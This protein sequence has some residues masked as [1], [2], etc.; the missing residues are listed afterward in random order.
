MAYYESLREYL[1][2]LDKAGKLVTIKSPINKD[3]QLG[4]L[5]LLQDKGLP[6][7]QRKAFLFTNVFDSRGK[8]YD[9]PVAHGTLRV[10]ADIALKCRP[11]EVN[12][13]VHLSFQFLAQ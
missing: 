6:K 1:E 8:K 13:K 3:T 10:S 9:I 7:K 12:E 5:F 2:A 11:E 4:P